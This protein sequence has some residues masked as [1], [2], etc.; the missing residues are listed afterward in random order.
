M[1]ARRTYM[2]TMDG[3]WKRTPFFQ[4]YMAREVTSFFVAAYGLL[5]LVGLVK[6]S[7][8][9]E[10]F[11]GWLEFLRSGWS[12]ALHVVLLVVFA[13]HTYSWFEIMPK[14][15]PPVVVGGRKLAPGTVTGLGI[16]AAVVASVVVLAI[17]LGLAR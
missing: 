16:A 4:R 11:A 2:R 6:L 5:L 10:A 12:I 1:T 17:A 14:T 15:M 13:Y 7:Q 9:P 8:G 3:W